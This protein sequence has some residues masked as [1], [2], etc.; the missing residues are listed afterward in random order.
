MFRSFATTALLG[1]STLSGLS[2]ATFNWANTKYFIAFG[3]SY[4]FIQGTAGVT[5]KSFIGSYTDFS[6]TST[7]LLNNQIVQSFTGTAEGGPNWV[8]YLTGCA[9]KNGQYLPSSCAIQ[10][11]DFAWSGASVSEQFLPRHLAGTVPLVN[12]TQQY[13]TYADPVL[14][15]ASNVKLDKTKALVAIWIGINDV[16]DSKTYKP[17]SISYKDFWTQEIQAVF[18]Q[19]VTS[20]LNSGFKNFLFLN[21]PPLDRIP[22]NQASSSPYP[23]TNGLSWWNTALASQVA[24]FQSNNA[25]TKAMLYDA[26]TFLNKVMNNPG[27][28]GITNTSNYCPGW[29]QADVLTNPGKYGCAPL[30]QYFW[31]NAVH[32]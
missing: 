14:K 9:T 24:S 19:S 7:K 16:F 30:N 12:Q 29:Q 10:P 26:N 6:F 18:Q 32:M 22:S 13:L 15:S 31:F 4:T 2:E 17:T 21:L 3:D 1:A 11:W 25:G 20:L 8:E 27:N 23:S 28:Y 5:N